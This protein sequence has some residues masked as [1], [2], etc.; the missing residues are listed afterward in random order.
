MSNKN[1]PHVVLLG[2]GASC[3]LLQDFGKVDK[4]GKPISSMDNFI[5]NMKLEYVF[6]DSL[7]HPKSKNLEEIYSNLYSN[8]FRRKL[9]MNL[10]KAIYDTFSEYKIPDE[11]TIYDMLILSLTA[12]DCIATFNWD[13][14][15]VQAYMR[16]RTITNNFPEIYYLHGNVLIGICNEHKRYGIVYRGKCPICNK[17]YEP[18]QLL[19]PIKHKNYNAVPSIKSFWNQFKIKLQ[20][21][22]IFTVFGYSG[23]KSDVEAIELVKSNWDAGKKQLEQLEVI[24]IQDENSL[25]KHWEDFY[26]TS[27]IEIHKTF[28][29][30]ILSK[31]PRKSV[32][33]LISQNEYAEPIDNSPKFHRGMNWEELT[34]VILS[35]K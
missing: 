3:A 33:S 19:Y 7:Y 22:Y 29:D 11:P 5:E 6:N 16:V 26:F 27:H 2:A 18:L 17:R 14:F 30:S 35:I 15:L 8:P 12:K 34:D 32:E 13:P 23:P 24:D 9:R 10:E 31:F 28:Y 1:R 4:N 21:A 20:D 25:K